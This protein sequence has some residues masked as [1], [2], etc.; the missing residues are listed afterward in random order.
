LD[1]SAVDEWWA[2][3]WGKPA[4]GSICPAAPEP[5]N[6]SNNPGFDAVGT[7]SSAWVQDPASFTYSLGSYTGAKLETAYSPGRLVGSYGYNG[8]MLASA[9]TRMDLST[10]CFR[11]ENELQNPSESPVF[12]DAVS[13]ALVLVGA[14]GTGPR[15]TDL[16]PSNLV[17]GERPGGAKDI[18]SKFGY[19]MSTFAIPRHG[20][21]PRRIPRNH[22]ASEKLPG[23]INVSFYDGHV[24][25]VQ[26][27]RLWQ[28]YWH[29]EYAAP[30]KRPGLQ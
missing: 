29:K 17:T 23:A 3:T 10:Y 7:V 30:A 12:G 14:A 13:E 9:W 5:P 19:G 26:I 2:A 24:E 16:P 18:S 28:L 8:W 11:S 25:T 20:S 27:E 21:R 6:T 4:K 22:P 1:Q 15:A